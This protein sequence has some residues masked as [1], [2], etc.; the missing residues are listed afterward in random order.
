LTQGY[1]KEPEKGAELWH[2]GWLHTGDVASISPDG[3]LVIKDRIKDVIK[4]GGEWISSLAL[5]NY[6]SQSEVVSQVAVVGV[7]DEQ[8]GER[9]FAMIVPAEGAQVDESVIKQHLQ[10]Y[11]ESGDIAKW[12]I[13]ER[14]SIVADIPKTSVGKINK[15]LIREQVP[16]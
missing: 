16:S 5:E 7:P 10:Q 15:K 13:P 11:V 6:I 2:G 9:P 8:W 12:A 1:Y 4:T 14:I 3:T